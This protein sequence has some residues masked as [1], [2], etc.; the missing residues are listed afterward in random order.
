MVEDDEERRRL[1]LPK[2]DSDGL[3]PE[4]I[5]DILNRVLAGLRTARLGARRGGEP[6]S[7]EG[8]G[9]P[10]AHARSTSEL[11]PA[12]SRSMERCRSS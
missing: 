3:A 11:M 2:A 4:L 6:V 9:S 7:D 1:A 8:K 10:P 12:S 5:G